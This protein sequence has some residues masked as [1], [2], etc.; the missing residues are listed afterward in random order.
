MGLYDCFENDSVKIL[1]NNQEIISVNDLSS[2]PILSITDLYIE[3]YRISK[4]NG[5]IKVYNESIFE[6]LIFINLNKQIELIII[7]NNYSDVFQVDFK[8]GK[9][10]RVIGCNDHRRDTKIYYL[11]KNSYLNK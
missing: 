6:K 7:R 3:Y 1:V 10:I 2:D 5:L 11:K 8:K 9:K 4:R